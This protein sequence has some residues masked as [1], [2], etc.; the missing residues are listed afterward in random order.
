LDRSFTT[1]GNTEANSINPKI[2]K[3]I[4][5]FKNKDFRFD[6]DLLLA[7]EKFYLHFWAS[8]CAL[9]LIFVILFITFHLKRES[10]LLIFTIS[11]RI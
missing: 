2:P 8:F 7:L 10:V 3:T 5:K 9:F 4:V 1:A 11:K 6:P